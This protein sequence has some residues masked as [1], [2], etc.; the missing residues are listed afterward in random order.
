MKA[1]NDT[2]DPEVLVPSA[3]VFGEYPKAVTSSEHPPERLSLSDRS[4]I[5]RVARDE[6]HMSKLRV[7]RAIKHAV[8][9]AVDRL[10]EPGDQVL[11]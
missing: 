7:I 1:V 8:P 11:V 2:S 3:L 9:R 4:K 10:F 6:K 5:A